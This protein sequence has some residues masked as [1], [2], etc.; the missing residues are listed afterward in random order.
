MIIAVAR[1]NPYFKK[2]IINS[3][4]SAKLLIQGFQLKFW[5]QRTRMAMSSCPSKVKKDVTGSKGSIYMFY[6]LN[7]SYISHRE[8]ELEL[9]ALIMGFSKRKIEN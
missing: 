6:V 1:S 2:Y 4:I 3:F 8:L 9:D 5:T 7:E